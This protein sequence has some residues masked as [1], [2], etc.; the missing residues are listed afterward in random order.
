MKFVCLKLLICHPV[1]DC[2]DCQ[3]FV[4]FKDMFERAPFSLNDFKS[5][6][7]LITSL[8]RIGKQQL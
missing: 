5:A 1:C 4:C 6:N 2:D 3:T 8:I 7:S